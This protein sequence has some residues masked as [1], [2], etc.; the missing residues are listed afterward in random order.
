M[1]SKFFSQIAKLGQRDLL[2]SYSLFFVFTFFLV[3]F[4][5][6]NMGLIK[7]EQQFSHLAD[8]LSQGKIYLVEQSLFANPN[9]PEDDAVLRQGHYYWSEGLFP[10]IILIPFVFLFKLAGYAFYQ[11][12][13]QFFLVV[14]ILFLCYKICLR[15]GYVHIDSLYLSLAFGAASMFLGVALVSWGWYYSQVVTVCLLFLAIYEYLS[16]QR[17]WLIGLIFGLLVLT[18]VTASLGIIFFVLEVIFS[19]K[20]DKTKKLFQLVSPFVIFFL[21][22]LFYNFIR[23]GNFLEE[24]YSF[25]P[26]IPTLARARDYGLFSLIHLPGN[27][28]YA[29][30]AAPLPIYKDSLSHTLTFPFFTTNPWG[31]SVFIT[32]PYLIY[33]FFLK[34]KDKI[35]IFLILTI[36]TIAVPVF[37]FYGIG[38]RQF[39]FRYALDLWPFLFFLF[40]RNYW[41]QQ[42]KLTTGI[43]VLILASSLFNLYLFLGFFAPYQMR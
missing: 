30:L 6:F 1:A 19:Q 37:L 36:L 24:G 26:V 4:L 43:K 10:A 3:L 38:Y 40:S 5:Y 14:A 34:Y 13:L 25:M 41:Q 16:H 31:M 15:I 12:Y 35:S 27:L 11:G 18:R 22:L 21:L 42:K 29:F 20:K 23:Y 2:L 7:K 17:H 28:Y 39:G 33:L 9:K 32:S 8:S